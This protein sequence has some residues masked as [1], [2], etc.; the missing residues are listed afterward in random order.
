MYSHYNPEFLD[1]FPDIPQQYTKLQCVHA[2]THVLVHS[3]LLVL[4][5]MTLYSCS[6]ILQVNECQYNHENLF[7]L[8]LVAKGTIDR[9]VLVLLQKK[10][11]MYSHY[12]S[13]N[14][15]KSHQGWREYF[16]S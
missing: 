1:F 6:K 8:L 15:K 13:E 14:F 10:Q 3:P 11:Q 12:K 7:V 9:H 2:H 4:V 5:R 16:S